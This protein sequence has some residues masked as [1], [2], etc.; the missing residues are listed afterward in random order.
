MLKSSGKMCGKSRRLYIDSKFRKFDVPFLCRA[1]SSERTVL[2]VDADTH[3]IEDIKHVLSRLRDEGGAVETRL[4][5]PPARVTNKKWS[6]LL[7]E[8]DI[9]FRPV[10][11]SENPSK[12]PNDEAIVSAMQRL[13]FK[14]WSR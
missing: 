13:F 9:T 11:R 6:Q 1:R 14:Q 4:F 7:Q 2:L 5:G 3:C 12:E 8:P 10:L